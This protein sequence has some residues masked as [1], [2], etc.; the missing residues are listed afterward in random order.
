MY[1]YQPYFL[2]LVFPALLDVRFLDL[3]LLVTAVMSGEGALAKLGGRRER[4][5]EKTEERSS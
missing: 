1:F 5:V 2:V 4:V 3:V